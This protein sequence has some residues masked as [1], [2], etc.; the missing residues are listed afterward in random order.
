MK[1]SVAK[2]VAREP[3]SVRRLLA[4]G[5]VALAVVHFL[6]PGFT[7]ERIDATLLILLGAAVLL[8]LLPWE[9]A[10]AVEAGPGGVT[11]TLAQPQV[12]DAVEV[13]ARKAQERAQK[14]HLPVTDPLRERLS[15]REE[16]LGLLQHARVLWVDDNPST[17]VTERRL[18]RLLGVYVETAIS[19]D[20]AWEAL[21]RD[22]DF[23]LII[24]DIQRGRPDAENGRPLH[25]GVRF[26][27]ELRASSDPTIRSLPIIFYSAFPESALGQ[28]LEPLTGTSPEPLAT[29][30]PDSLLVTVID[31]IVEIRSRPI[32]TP[33]QK[34]PTGFTTHPTRPIIRR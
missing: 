7:A 25:Q 5:A 24:S 30:L 9:E 1:L 12:Q 27:R 4:L 33:G 32:A 34:T 13:V 26:A 16:Q 19:S 31:M 23:D 15:R 6:A 29:T 10:S 17:L 3:S 8:L 18:L 11:L 2:L 21:E 20:M 28:I 22:S 14:L